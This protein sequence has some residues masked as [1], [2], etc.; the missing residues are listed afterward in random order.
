MVKGIFA[1]A[2]DQAHA[3]KGNFVLK[4]FLGPSSLILLDGA[5]HM[6]QRRMMLP[7]FHGERMHAYGRTMLDVAHD[8]VDSWPLDRPFPVHRPM[9]SI[10]LQIILRTV[11]GVA[12]GPLPREEL[13]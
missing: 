2:A 10:T 5:E 1:W 6:R 12:L 11:F 7:A 13:A 3:G 4:P 9:Q 8:S